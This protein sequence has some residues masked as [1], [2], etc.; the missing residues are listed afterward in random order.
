MNSPYR[1]PSSHVESKRM[2]HRIAEDHEKERRTKTE[3]E[4]ANICVR[5][6]VRTCIRI[7]RIIFGLNRTKF[8]SRSCL[9][10]RMARHATLSLHTTRPSTIG[11][12]FRTAGCTSVPIGLCVSVMGS[13]GAINSLAC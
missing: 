10:Y 6:R 2:K 13:G 5:V 7:A 9:A 3:K 11:H 4:K 1:Q 12:D 8:S